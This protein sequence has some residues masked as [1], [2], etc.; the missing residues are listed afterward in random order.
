MVSVTLHFTVCSQG[1]FEGSRLQGMTLTHIHTHTHT[2][3]NTYSQVRKLKSCCCDT[4]CWNVSHGGMWAI[5]LPYTHAGRMKISANP[6][7]Q[8]L[9]PTAMPSPATTTS[10]ELLQYTITAVLCL[11]VRRSYAVQ[12]SHPQLHLVVNKMWTFHMLHAC[13]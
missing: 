5:H 10:S 4:L 7:S 11:N 2:H 9:V 8:W 3:I 13:H 6:L 1:T 12:W